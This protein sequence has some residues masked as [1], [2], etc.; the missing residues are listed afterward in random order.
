MDRMHRK[1]YLSWIETTVCRFPKFL[2]DRAKLVNNEFGEDLDTCS[3]DKRE[4]ETEG[5]AGPATLKSHFSNHWYSRSAKDLAQNE[6]G[7]TYEKYKA[8]M[9]DNIKKSHAER[10]N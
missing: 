2:K 8:T 10:R 9:T 5:S 7:K 4:C 6:S 1:N 3:K